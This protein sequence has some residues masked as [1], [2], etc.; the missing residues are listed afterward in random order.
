PTF[1][2]PQDFR[3]NAGNFGDDVETEDWIALRLRL[4]ES[5]AMNRVDDRARVFETDPFAGPVRAAC[6][7]GV[8]Q[9]NARLVFAHLFREQLG[10]FA[11]MPDEKW[12]A[13]AG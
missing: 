1:A 7:T 6:P 3:G 12:S 10:V 5:A 13:E 4:S 8:D 9:P 2:R 11:R